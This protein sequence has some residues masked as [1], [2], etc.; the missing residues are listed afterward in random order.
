MARCAACTPRSARSSSSTTWSSFE[1]SAKCPTR[2]HVGLTEQRAST[3]S[4]GQQLGPSFGYSHRLLDFAL[5]VEGRSQQA[6]GLRVLMGA[7]KIVAVAR[8]RVISG[9]PRRSGYPF[10]R[11]LSEQPVAGGLRVDLVRARVH[12]GQTLIRQVWRQANR[13]F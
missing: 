1:R 10:Q 9:A 12:N 3:P 11:L 4:G 7:L 8:T 5:L 13:V 6:Q 2:P